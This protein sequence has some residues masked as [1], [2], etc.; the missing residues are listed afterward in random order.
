MRLVEKECRRRGLVVSASK[1]ELLTGKDALDDG[2]HPDRDMA[3]YF[4][5]ID[6]LPEARRELKGIL[7]NALKEDG[8]LDASSARF[9]L[10]R[11]SRIRER[12]VLQTIVD[13]LQDLAPIA[14]V[15]AAYLRHFL[16]KDLVIKGSANFLSD[17]ARC[18]S[19]SLVT[20]LF[21]AMLEKHENMPDE[22][23]YHA[24]RY[25]KDRNQPTYLRAIAASVFLRGRRP[26]DVAWLKAEA[27]RESDPMLLRGYAVA[28]HWA[29]GLDHSMAHL[30]VAKSPILAWTI[31]YL[32]GRQGLPSLLDRD[33]DIWWS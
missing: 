24:G 25:V 1:T 29:D 18:Y 13:R 15:V 28:L 7:W 2:R 17:P 26:A 4:L 8:H 11:L 5:N 22:W 3:T 30:L 32:D 19:T 16:E 9:S 31:E 6:N 12:T 10:W 14:S 21:A 20:W 23:V 33:R 27:M